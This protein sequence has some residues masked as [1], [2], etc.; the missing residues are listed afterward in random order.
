M[1]PKS[2]LI[3]E[4]LESHQELNIM[5]GGNLSEGGRKNLSISGIAPDRGPRLL[6]PIRSYEEGF[7]E[8]TFWT[9]AALFEEFGGWGEVGSECSKGEGTYPPP[10]PPELKMGKFVELKV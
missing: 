7:E 6:W 3:E 2:L 4:M 1:V 9:V 5:C 8:V 10:L